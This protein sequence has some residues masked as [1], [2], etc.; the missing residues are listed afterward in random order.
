LVGAG[1]A[2]VA[3]SVVFW[4]LRSNAIS[5]LDDACGPGRQHCPESV[6]SNYNAGQTDTLVSVALGSAGVV[7]A[8]VGTA[9]LLGGRKRTRV[10]AI[11]PIFFSHGGGAALYKR[12]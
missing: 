6:R 8:G 4:I 5:T 11:A 7:A 1:T 10:T 3:G 12:F 9:L 2:A